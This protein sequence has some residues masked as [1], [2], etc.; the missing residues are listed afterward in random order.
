M[1]PGG[2]R[3]HPPAAAGDQGRRRHD[4]RR[5]RGVRRVAGHPRRDQRVVDPPGDE[6]AVRAGRGRGAGRRPGAGARRRAGRGR[7]L[8]EDA[9]QGPDAGRLAGPG[10]A[11]GR[12]GRRIGRGD[13]GA[14]ALAGRR[15]L[16][17]PRLPRVRPGRRAGRDAAARG[18]R[19][20]ARHPAARPAGVE[21]V[22][23]A[24]AR[25]AGQG[26]RA[27]AADP[28][29]GQ[30]DVHRA[31]AALPGLRRGQAVRPG[32]QGDRRAAVPRAVHALG[33]LREHHPDPGA[34]PQAGRGAGR[35]RPGR[36]QPR[37]QRPGRVPGELPARGA[38]PDPGAGP[39]PDRG[40]R[41][42]AAGPQAD[43]AV[44]AQGPLRPVHV[45]P[46]LHAQGPVHHRD[47][48]ARPGDPAPGARRR[49]GQLQ[50]DGRRVGGVPAAHRGAGGPRQDAA[51]RGRGQPWN[52]SWSRPS[53]PGTTTWPRRPAG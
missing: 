45:L 20:R 19:H 40:R 14:A 25:G 2:A 24:A 53:G 34:A 52:G 3:G 39:D 6:H 32:R 41:A 36:G 44:P 10:R 42:A 35:H 50:R 38:V 48:A 4:A 22:R 33:V 51:R 7:G 23:R 49:V 31:P 26:H 37:R 13:R 11:A 30:L 21:R 8:P 43:P 46:G 27:A 9:R 15:A 5:A 29:Q 12:R 18:A 47:P 17:V 1:R 16:H 28:D